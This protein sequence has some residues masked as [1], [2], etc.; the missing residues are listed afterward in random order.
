M[1]GK[2]NDAIIANINDKTKF[3]KVID[4]EDECSICLDDIEYGVNFDCKHKFCKTCILSFINSDKHT[5]NCSYCRK[6]I[7]W[8]KITL[9]KSKKIHDTEIE[10]YKTYKMIIQTIK[11]LEENKA[12]F[13]NK[14][15]TLILLTQ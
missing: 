6:K 15:E 2:L 3:T 9:F 7:K 12:V 5:D 1:D 11:N 13:K 8:D 10:R 14:L 4:D